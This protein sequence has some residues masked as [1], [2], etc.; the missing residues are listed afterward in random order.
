M[1]NKL[2]LIGILAV[3]IGIG[4]S[5][6]VEAHYGSNSKVT[7]VAILVIISLILVLYLISIK[8]YLAAIIMASMALP[9]I[10]SLIGMYLKNLYL[11]FGGIGS[12]FILIPLTI[13]L[14]SKFSNNDSH[15]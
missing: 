1:N 14:I 5:R 15:R 8:K 6:V 2:K 10:V 13:K 9:L 7:I 11:I 3:F 4:L 12:V